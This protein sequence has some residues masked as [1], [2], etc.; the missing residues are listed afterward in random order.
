MRIFISGKITDT[1]DY[2][3]RFLKAERYLTK[4]GYNP[5]NPAAVMAQLP[6]APGWST[7]MK[8]TLALLE[9]C[10]SIYML[11]GWRNSKGAQMEHAFA[12]G[13]GLRVLYEC[14]EPI[15]H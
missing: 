12:K 1:D 13:L 9:E 3:E 7:C 15:V 6:S 10:D 4:Q 5:I 14:R 11:R 8:I 2:M